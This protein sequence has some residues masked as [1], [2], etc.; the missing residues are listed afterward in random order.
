M[1]YKQ[2]FS[3][4]DHSLRFDMLVLLRNRELCI[5]E[6]EQLLDAKQYQISK[7]MKVLKE[8]GLVGVRKQE[9]YHYYSLNDNK[10]LRSMLDLIVSQPDERISE[11]HKRLNTLDSNPIVCER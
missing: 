10:V 1:I 8:L 11:L 5:C 4:F 2:L 6:F 9:K 7:H 3:A